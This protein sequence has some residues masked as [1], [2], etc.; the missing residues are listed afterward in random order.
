MQ[1]IRKAPSATE[2]TKER[3]TKLTTARRGDGLSISLVLDVTCSKHT[4]E[5]RLGSTGDSNDIPV[6]VRVDLIPDKRRGRLMA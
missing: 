5:V 1:P 3:G 6:R 2:Q 4:L